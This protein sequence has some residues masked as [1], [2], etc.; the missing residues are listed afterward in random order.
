M[1]IDLYSP[2]NVNSKQRFPQAK[3]LRRNMVDSEYLK[4]C[5]VLNL[6]SVRY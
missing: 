2:I 5:E 4:K 6:K 1:K 3:V